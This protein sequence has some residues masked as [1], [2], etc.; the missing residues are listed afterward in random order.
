MSTSSVARYY[1]VNTRRFLHF[2]TGRAAS[3]IHRPVWG[4]G[5]QD[6]VDALTYVHRLL[7]EQLDLLGGADASCVVD[8]GCGTGATLRWLAERGLG[9]GVGVTVSRRQAELATATSREPIAAGC[10]SF[11]ELDF[12]DSLAPI[13]AA[14]ADLVYAIESFAHASSPPRFFANAARLLR[15]GGRL[16]VCDDSLSERGAGLSQTGKAVHRRGNPKRTR[17]LTTSKRRSDRRDHADR[18]LIEKFRTGWRLSSLVSNRE[19]NRFAHR[20]GFELEHDVDLTTYLRTRT[21]RDLAVA[22]ATTLLGPLLRLRGPSGQALIGGAAL[23]RAI[24]RGLIEYRLR[25][26]RWP[27]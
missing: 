16:V 21:A 20:T 8:L 23:S 6:R 12:C 3:V 5:V 14:H 4:P 13:P 26:F 22:S 1:D 11:L 9:K 18:R 15:P 17:R 2:G 7:L 27:G 10:L 19:L 25:V 24:E